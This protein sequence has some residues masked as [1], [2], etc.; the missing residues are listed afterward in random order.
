MI[1]I[2]IGKGTS[3]TVLKVKES[4]KVGDVLHVQDSMII[5]YASDI[6]AMISNR[7]IHIDSQDED[8]E[9]EDYGRIPN[10]TFHTEE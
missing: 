5:A 3:A 1:Y 10:F 2:G 8:V 9:T 4:P 6:G 7:K